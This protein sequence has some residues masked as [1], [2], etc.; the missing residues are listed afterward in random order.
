MIPPSRKVAM[1]L[2]APVVPGAIEC[3]DVRTEKSDILVFS[4]LQWEILERLRLVGESV[5][6]FML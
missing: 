1:A 2:R 5:N 3:S 4:R 6:P